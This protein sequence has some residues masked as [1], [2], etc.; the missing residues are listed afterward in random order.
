M[1]TVYPSVLIIFSHSYGDRKYIPHGKQYRGVYHIF[2]YYDGYYGALLWA[3]VTGNTNIQN[4]ARLL[5]ATE[6]HAA[7]VYWHMYPNTGT[8]DRDQPYPEQGMPN[9]VTVGNVM[10]WQSGAW[11]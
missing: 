10:D 11:L 1:C 2:P 7:Q 4:Y 6:Q 9:L 3:Q 8:N 5:I